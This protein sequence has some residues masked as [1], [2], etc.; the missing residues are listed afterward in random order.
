MNTTI[1]SATS[2]RK[3]RADDMKKISTRGRKREARRWL[4]ETGQRVVKI[5][6]TAAGA[7]A[8]FRAWEE[9]NERDPTLAV[10]VNEVLDAKFRRE[11]SW[12]YEQYRAAMTRRVLK[13][14]RER[15]RAEL[16]AGLRTERD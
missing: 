4:D 10:A 12:T 14:R 13:R 7:A 9:L 11:A 2:N 3:S 16:E 1:G 15:R 6:P 5:R 8:W